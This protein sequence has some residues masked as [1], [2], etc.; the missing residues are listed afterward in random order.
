MRLAE[1][2]KL[3][4]LDWIVLLPDLARLVGDARQALADGRLT[5]EEITRLGTELVSLV[6]R[7]VGVATP[8]RAA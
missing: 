2:A 7:A 4:P 1:L 3:H 6:A 8:T 5:P